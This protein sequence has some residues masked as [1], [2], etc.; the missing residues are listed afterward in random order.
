MQVPVLRSGL[1][2]LAR[3]RWGCR[4]SMLQGWV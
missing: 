2:D 1:H 3:A 4:R